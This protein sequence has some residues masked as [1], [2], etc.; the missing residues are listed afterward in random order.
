MSLLRSEVTVHRENSSY[1]MVNLSNESDS[2]N[3]ELVVEKVEVETAAR[4]TE[5]IN[6]KF[7]EPSDVET[8]WEKSISPQQQKL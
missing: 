6:P 8:E 3:K 1:E 7:V 2:N 5:L 4:G